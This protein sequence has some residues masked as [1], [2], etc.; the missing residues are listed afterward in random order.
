ML[1]LENV[2]VKYN[3]VIACKKINL[4]VKKADIVTVVGS[5]GAGKSSL[6]KAI[7]GMNKVTQGKI[8]FEDEEITNLESHKICRLGIGQVAEGRQIFSGLT[9]LENLKLGSFVM[10]FDNR[11]IENNLENIFLIFPKLKERLKQIA[12]SMSG[13]EQQMLS[14]GRCLMSNP[15]LILFDEPSLGLAP[16]IVKNMFNLIKKLNESGITILLVE[17]NVRS[18]LN[19]SNYCYVLENGRITLEGDSLSLKDSDKVKNAYLGI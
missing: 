16:I 7:F 4:R 3:Q 13:G 9:V 17:Q 12:G 19:I 6:I 11:M 14:I 15:K 1:I 5:N 10:N 2:E 8:I 18:S